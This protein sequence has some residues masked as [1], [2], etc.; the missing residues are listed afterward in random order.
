MQPLKQFLQ[1]K[2]G[3]SSY[4]IPVLLILCMFAAVIF[5]GVHQLSENETR[6]HEEALDNVELDAQMVSQQLNGL[7]VSLEATAPVLA[8]E[9]GFTRPQMLQAMSDRCGK[10]AI[11][12]L[13]YGPIRTVL[14]LTFRAR[15][16][17]TWPTAAISTN[18]CRASG[19]VNMSRLGYL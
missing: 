3:A 12:I 10:P 13:R 19:P 14:L 8:S 16:I 4:I 6:L 15:I 9:N 5:V 18:L 11:L 7:Y 2:H 1:K 17:L